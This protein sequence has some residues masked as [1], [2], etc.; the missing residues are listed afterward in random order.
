MTFRIPH[1][2]TVST[3]KTTGGIWRWY[4]WSLQV[5]YFNGTSEIADVAVNQRI[6]D[7]L[8]FDVPL[9]VFSDMKQIVTGQ[10]GWG[11]ALEWRERFTVAWRVLTTGKVL[12]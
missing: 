4:G 9:N 7:K 11:P 6:I 10:D 12:P 5:R 1:V 3:A 8:V 2:D